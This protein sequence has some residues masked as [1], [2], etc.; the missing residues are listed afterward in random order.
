LFALAV[1][2]ARTSPS[3]LRGDAEPPLRAP[4]PIRREHATLI[5]VCSDRLR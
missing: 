2:L 4:I 1:E 3:V 5:K